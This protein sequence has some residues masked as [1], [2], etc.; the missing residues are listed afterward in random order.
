[1]LIIIE[2]PDGSGKSTL[3][4]QLRKN[5]ER[6][7]LIV[8]SAGYPR[9]DETAYRYVLA[10][11][12]LKGLM[13][14]SHV[15]CDRYIPISESIYRPI[16]R[17][18]EFRSTSSDFTHVDAVVYCRPAVDQIWRNMQ[19]NPQMTGVSENWRKIVSAYDDLMKRLDEFL[20]TPIIRYDYT[21]GDTAEDLAKRLRIP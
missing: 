15:V 21:N 19:V 18:D 12:R 8:R 14:P 3:I 1:M 17:G 7:F 20:T 16:C 13:N 2:G 5:S 9:D 11:S 6:Y 4:E 10:M